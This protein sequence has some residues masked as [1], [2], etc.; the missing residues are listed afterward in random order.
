[1]A[2]DRRAFLALIVLPALI[3][4]AP[5]A[6]RA[7][8][9]EVV[10]IVRALQDRM[11][12]VVRAAADWMPRRRFEALRPAIGASF[13]LAFMAKAA[14]GPG[15][16][17]LPSAQRDEWVAAFG[18]YAA[19]TYAQRLG[20]FRA[21]NFE[22]DAHVTPREDMLVVSTRLVPLEG[23]PV[24]VDYV[25]RAT[26]GGWRIVDI[27][28]NGSISELTQWRRALRGQPAGELRKRTEFMLT[29]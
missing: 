1:M 13:D 22:R 4:F 18:D 19:A 21:K 8:D 23:E 14:Y 6:A 17:D 11:L 20:G 12:E 25:L 24:P 3:A 26:G 28:A 27:L 5:L 16:D 29:P 15:F 7:G 10:A 9:D 2:C